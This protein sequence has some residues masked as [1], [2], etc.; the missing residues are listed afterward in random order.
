LFRGY[1][2]QDYQKKFRSVI[3]DKFSRQMVDESTCVKK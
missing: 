2:G 3:H 1:G